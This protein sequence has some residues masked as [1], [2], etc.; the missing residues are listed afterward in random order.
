[1]DNVKQEDV[2]RLGTELQGLLIEAGFPHILTFENRFQAIMALC[3]HS[4]ILSRKAELDQFIS[5]LGPLI[6]IVRKHPDLA[7][8]LFVAGC[9]TPP[10]SEEVLSLVKY[11][12]VDD[13]H[14]EFFQKY[15][16]EECKCTAFD[17]TMCTQ[18]VINIEKALY[19][20]GPC[21]LHKA[22]KNKLKVLL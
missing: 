21:L 3:L 11:E 19:L 4:V 13:K 1:M 7:A 10:T 5:G 2:A 17:Y 8:P 18:N 16:R 22:P 6:N 9:A 14:K 12:D 15:V 20:L